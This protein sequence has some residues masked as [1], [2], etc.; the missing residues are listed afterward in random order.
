MQER[1]KVRC[2]LMQKIF[3]NLTENSKFTFYYQNQFFALHNLRWNDG[4]PRCTAKVCV[5][6]PSQAKSSFLT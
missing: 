3:S 1:V 6:R 4:N 5:I 2:N